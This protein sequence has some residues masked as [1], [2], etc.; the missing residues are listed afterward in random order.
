[1]KMQFTNA[2]NICHEMLLQRSYKFIKENDSH[3]TY[4]Q[5]DDTLVYVFFDEMPKLNI[6]NVKDYIKLMEKDFI[7]H[8]I[9]V[10]NSCA[11]AAAKKIIQITNDMNIEL[12][13]VQDLQFNITK[14]RLYR[15]HIPLSSSEKENFVKKY[16]D[17][18]PI[19]LRT[20]PICLFFN[21][22]K[23]TILKIIRKENFVSFRI[24]K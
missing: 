8:G 14:H 24:V 12:F 13:D 11:T 22:K 21:F 5:S 1:M 7:L 6:N 9:I 20:D 10:Y 4:T 2:K 16:G 3:K 19:I 18:I 23:G 17:K 15:P